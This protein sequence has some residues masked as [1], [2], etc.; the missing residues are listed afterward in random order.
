MWIER[1][2]QTVNP[3]NWRPSM[4][5]NRGSVSFSWRGLKKN[6]SSLFKWKLLWKRGLNFV[7]LNFTRNLMQVALLYWSI[8]KH[9]MNNKPLTINWQIKFITNATNSWTSAVGHTVPPCFTTGGVLE[10]LE[11]VK[12]SQENNSNHIDM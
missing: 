1:V 5:S 9:I 11:T 3:N 2:Q 10:Y 4:C 7:L 6:V 12:G 8:L